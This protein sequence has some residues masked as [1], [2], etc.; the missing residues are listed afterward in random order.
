MT[1]VQSRCT[2]PAEEVAAVTRTVKDPEDN[3]GTRTIDSLG[4]F[5]SNAAIGYN[6]AAS[7]INTLMYFLRKE[8]TLAEAGDDPRFIPGRAA[9]IMYNGE[10]VGIFGET[11]PQ[12]LE[13]WG[14]SMPSIMAEIDLD[15]LMN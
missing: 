4:F 6:D 3:S 10:R 13:S 11:H 8:Y 7:Y 9:V 12:V 5:S 2:V 1:I 15:K 14:C